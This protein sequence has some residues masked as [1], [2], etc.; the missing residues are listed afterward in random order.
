MHVDSLKIP[1]SFQLV[2]KQVD[3]PCDGILGRDFF[4]NTGAQ[5]CYASG[6]LTLGTGSSKVS[7]TLSPI[8]AGSQTQ[9]VRSLLLPSRTELMVKLPVKAGTHFREG[10][11][12]KL[13]I[14][15]GLYLAGAITK[16]REG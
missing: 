1:F 13:E 12:E 15:E 3:S 11:M 4:E 8:G 10:V 9:G 5:I 2:G 7:K 16:F 6:T 14:Q